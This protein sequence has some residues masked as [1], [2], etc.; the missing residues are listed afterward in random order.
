MPNKNNFRSNSA[1]VAAVFAAIASIGAAPTV[2]AADTANA[3]TD[4][5]SAGTS[6]T[7]GEV[8]RNISIT[9][10]DF[11]VPESPALAALGSSS[12]KV[13]Q[14]ATPKQLVTQ[15]VQGTDANGNIQ[16]GVA[17]DFVPYLLLRGDRQ[18]ALSDYNENSGFNHTRTLSNI[19]VSLA[20]VKDASAGSNAVRLAT[21]LR[22][23]ILD[24]GDTRSSHELARCF[25]NIMP[26]TSDATSAVEVQKKFD[27]FPTSKEAEKKY[28]GCL[29]QAKKDNWNR[30]SVDVGIAPSWTSTNGS[31]G[32][33]SGSTVAYYLNADYGFENIP[34]LSRYAQLLGHF[35][36][37]IHDV[38]PKTTTTPSYL[39]D[40]ETY[41]LK[42]R[43]CADCAGSGAAKTYLALEAD[44]IEQRAEASH[45]SA[46]YRQFVISGE[47]RI[48]G[49]LYLSLQFGGTTKHSGQVDSNGN[50]FLLGGFKW[51]LDYSSQAASHA[52][53]V[54]APKKPQSSSSRPQ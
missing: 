5:G 18:P 54:Y 41:G 47:H 31:F 24:M 1:P 37:T 12:T 32:D 27:D 21:G 49:S 8:G 19:Q 43:V 6:V 25:T 14:A 33:L 36:S 7:H 42:L 2:N 3:T 44:R 34:G 50:R 46:N 52:A 45:P 16:S 39:Q 10:V 26:D 53:V 11:S 22:Y 40:T 15:L 51:S 23:V 28:Q 38:I 20:T 30:S 17:L 29:S 48:A 35:Q 13:T 9:D 4:A